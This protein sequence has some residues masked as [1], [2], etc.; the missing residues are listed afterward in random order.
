MP[1]GRDVTTADGHMDERDVLDNSGH[2]ELPGR[3]T[4][5]ARWS[6]RY[7]TRPTVVLL[8]GWT[9][10]A[11]LNWQPSYAEIADHYNVIALDHHGHGRGIRRS[12]PFSLAECADDAAAL[13]RSLDVRAVIVVG[14]SMGGAIAQLMWRQNRDL[15]RGLVLCATGATFNQTVREHAVFS[16]AAAAAKAARALP[17]ALRAKA[18]LRLMA[19]VHEAPVEEWIADDVALHDWLNIVQAGHA[20]GAHDSRDWLHTIDVPTSVVINAWDEVVPAM[21]QRELTELIPEARRHLVDGGHPVCL[22]HPGRF[23]PVLLDAISD[24][25]DITRWSSYP[26]SRRS[27]IA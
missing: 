7:P 2:I 27:A 15:V 22:A 19:G 1:M 4:T 18:A 3:G 5:F 24:A 12:T 14:Y 11:D 10:T 13:V 17:A 20:I 8:H 23:L 21:R 9:A 6:L 26:R 16:A 25:T